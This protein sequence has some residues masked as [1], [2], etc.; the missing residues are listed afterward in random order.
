[1]SAEIRTALRARRLAVG[2]SQQELANAS[3]RD[4]SDISNYER[5]QNTPSMATLVKLADALGCDV[6]LVPREPQRCQN[7]APGYD[8]ERGVYT[9]VAPGRSE[10]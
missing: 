4:Q 1:M 7:C 6:V 10:S 5:G 9:P 3:G 8:C 2:M